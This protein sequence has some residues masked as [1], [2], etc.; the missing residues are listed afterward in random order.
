[1]SDQI[2]DLKSYAEKIRQAVAEG[3]VMPNGTCLAC[4]F[5]EALLEELYQRQ[6]WT[7][8]FRSVYPRRWMPSVREA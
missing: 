6:R 3:I 4:T 8:N 2:F 7:G 1:M 5:N